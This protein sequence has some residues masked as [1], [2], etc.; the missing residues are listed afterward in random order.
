MA[1]TK[2]QL[3]DQIRKT[4][5]RRLDNRCQ[6]HLVNMLIKDPKKFLDEYDL[7]FMGHHVE[8]RK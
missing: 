7:A 5:D 3:K 2:K 1:R 6:R 8:A 4:S